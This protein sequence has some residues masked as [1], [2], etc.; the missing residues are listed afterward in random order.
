MARKIRMRRLAEFTGL[1]AVA[2]AVVLAWSPAGVA[3]EKEE[4]R[5]RVFAYHPEYANA[6]PL[7]GV[8]TEPAQHDGGLRVSRVMED[9]PA[10][11]VGIREDDVIVSAGGHDLGEPLEDE[12]KRNFS[13]SGSLA[14]QRLRA[15]VNEVPEGEAIEV[16]VVREG[17]SMTFSVVPEVMFSDGT[18]WRRLEE[19]N[20]WKDLA[21]YEVLME[22]WRHEAERFRDQYERIREQPRVYSPDSIA[23]RRSTNVPIMGLLPSRGFE[24]RWD[25][26]RWRGRHGLDLLELN[27][28]LGS[29]FGTEEGVL[30]ADIENDSPLGLRPGDVVVA[31][32]GRQVDDIAELHRILGSYE[33]EEEIRFRIWRDGAETTLTGTI[34]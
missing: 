2:L 13:R 30:V 26:A 10:E 14:D 23:W 8:W 1:G 16:T 31:V 32:E 34:N 24:V 33:D 22:A 27:P 7:L 21:D 4:E 6:R 25:G 5:L 28:E 29:Y 18:R 15:L 12:E 20:E 19:V 9:G 11:G 17:E 3:Q